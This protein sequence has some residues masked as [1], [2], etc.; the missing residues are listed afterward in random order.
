MAVWIAAAVVFSV[1]LCAVPV[2]IALC[3]RLPDPLQ[4][5]TGVSLFFSGIALRAAGKRAAHNGKDKTLGA[6]RGSP[7][8][9][10]KAGGFHL[11]A[12]PAAWRL[13]R[14]LSRHICFEEV[15][16]TGRVSAAD[17]A[18]TAMICGSAN[19]LQNA[20]AA[21]GSKVVCLRVAPDFSSGKS[22]LNI[23]GML[24]IRVGHIILAPISHMKE[25][26]NLWKSTRSKA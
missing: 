9:R 10:E 25:I 19:I 5:G 7:S 15:T 8:P 20:L 24:S 2:Y 17:A 16:V 13:Y 1:Y 18:G 26:K 11:H 6:S 12:L 22:E 3:I 21:A 4:T 23:T 14:S